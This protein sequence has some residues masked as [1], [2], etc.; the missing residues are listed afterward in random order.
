M[1]EPST[2][3]YEPVIDREIAE[4]FLK[5]ADDPIKTHVMG[6][7]HDWWATAPESAID[8]Y[9]DILRAL[10]GADAFLA[11]RYLPPL[12]TL[13]DLAACPEGSLG[14]AYRNWIVDN[15]LEPN[16]TQKQHDVFYG[17]LERG[18]LDRMPDDVRYA[19]VRGYTLHDYL[20]TITGFG[21]DIAGELGMAG[22]HFA[23]L[24]SAYHAMRVAVTT[25]HIA[26]VNPRHATSAM[27]AVSGGWIMGRQW[28]NIHFVKWEEQLDRPLADIRAEYGGVTTA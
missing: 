4:L 11:E 25:A 3:T 9:A 22:F 16:L 19:F 7:V 20:H 26:F 23:Q 17:L 13:D 14:H 5:N 18:R 27:D 24:Q 12:V 10:P 21:P 1:N 28:R 15:G 8:Q 6:L 2:R